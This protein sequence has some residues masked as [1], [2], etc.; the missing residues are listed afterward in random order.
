MIINKITTG[1]VIQQW[2][3]KKKAWVS[4]EFTAGDQCDYENVYGDTS[5]E[6]GD[7]FQD[8]LVDKDGNEP[9]L[10]F[11]MVNPTETV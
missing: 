1:F 3:T 8:L 5:T 10:P 9:Y 2:D 11:D 7:S 6:G 4:Q